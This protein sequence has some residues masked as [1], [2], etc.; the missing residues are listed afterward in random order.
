MEVI[1]TYLPGNLFFSD[2]EWDGYSIISRGKT[3]YLIDFNKKKMAEL[4]IPFDLFVVKDKVF[5]LDE[6]RTKVLEISLK[7]L[8]PERNIDYPVI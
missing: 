8:F 3:Q 1:R 5:T 7:E 2:L 4:H 6:E